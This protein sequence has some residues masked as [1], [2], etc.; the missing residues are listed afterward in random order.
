MLD[1]ISL[2]VL[3]LGSG[4]GRG[5]GYR[6]WYRATGLPGWMRFGQVGPLGYPGG[7]QWGY[8]PVSPYTKE[9]ETEFLKG[10][11]APLKEELDAIDSRL[12]DLESEGQESE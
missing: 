3:G 1:P 8:P 12:R 7:Y 2:G 6:H 5:R 10:Q 4:G 9:Q 11:A